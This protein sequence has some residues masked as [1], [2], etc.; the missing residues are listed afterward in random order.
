MIGNIYMI[1]NP[2][3]NI[4]IGQ[5][6]N[7]KNRIRS[8]KYL[9]CKGQPKIYNSIKKYGFENHLIEILEVLQ[10]ANREVLFEKLNQ[11]EIFYIEKYN[12]CSESGLNCEIGGKNSPCS[13]E[14]IEK[15]RNS[16]LGK[17]HSEETKLKLSLIN[18]G[19]PSNR[20]GCKLS[21]DHRISLLKAITG[22]KSKYRKKIVCS[23]GIIY[24]S[25]TQASQSLNIIRNNINQVC[26]GKRKT[27]GGL[28]FNYYYD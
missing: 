11:L 17:K 23:N 19:K 12:T 21:T 1:I 3:N 25:I 13:Q 10:D 4:Y 20:K 24:D 16:K 26:L 2:K 22:R 5:T 18:S 8:Y 6:I 9:T 15:I 14:T 7:L 28:K 27:A